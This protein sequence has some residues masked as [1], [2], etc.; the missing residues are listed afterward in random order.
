M[1]ISLTSHRLLLGRVVL[2]GAASVALLFGAQGVAL[3][4][5]QSGPGP[6]EDPL[7]MPEYCKGIPWGKPA[8][9]PDLTLEVCD[10]RH[11]CHRESGG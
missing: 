10:A 7:A 6:C 9:L 8:P 2:V 1:E 3:A 4:G 5:H 11:D